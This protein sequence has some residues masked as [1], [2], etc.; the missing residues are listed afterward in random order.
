MTHRPP[1]DI[2]ADLFHAALHAVDPYEAVRRYEATLRA[3]YNGGGFE[4]LVVIGFG[5]ASCP[6]AK[7]VEDMLPGLITDGV[8]IT[9]YGHCLAPF[10]PGGIGP[11]GIGPGGIGP[12]GIGPGGIRVFEA[13]HPVPDE[14]G[15]R[16]AEEIISLL[17]RA[18]ERTLVLCLIS[19]GGSALCVAPYDGMGLAEKQAVTD[20]LLK[21]GATIDEL[22]TVR[23]HLSRVKGGRLAELAAP[24]RVVTLILSDVIGDKLDVIASGPTAPDPTIYQDAL[25]VL[26]KYMLMERSP[27]VALEIIYRGVSGIWPETPKAGNPLFGRVENIV[28]GSNKKALD[29]VAEKAA[30]LSLE[31]ALLSSELSGEAREAGRRLARAAREAQASLRRSGADCPLCLISGGETTV[32]VTGSGRG[33]RNTELALAFAI[34]VAGVEGITLLSAGTDG[35]DGPTD[36]AGAVVDGATVS[37]GLSAGLDAGTFLGNNNSYTFFKTTGELLITGPTGT[38]VMDLQLIFVR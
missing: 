34:E 7:A 29:A 12:G 27:Q 18:D 36:A 17:Q 22:N 30:A 3:A 9:K 11:G 5:K 25:A 35:T 6:M 26:D 14:N 31:T 28:I 38:N 33:G 8:V 10:I 19:G 2:L 32:T 21:A 23:K 13:G 37:R 16:G 15:V 1:R 4:R 24:A 20:L